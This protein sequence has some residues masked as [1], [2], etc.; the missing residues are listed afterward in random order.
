MD[1][2][3]YKE[4]IRYVC[5]FYNT[6]DKWFILRLEEYLN[7]SINSGFLD[8]KN[9]DEVCSYLKRYAENIF[10]INKLDDS[11]KERYLQ[12]KDHYLFKCSNKFLAQVSVSGTRLKKIASEVLI[13]KNIHNIV[14]IADSYDKSLNFNDLVQAGCLGILNSIQKYEVKNYFEYIIRGIQYEINKYVK[15]QMDDQKEINMQ[16]ENDEKYDVIENVE[17]KIFIEEFFQS[18]KG[19]LTKKEILVLFY[20]FGFYDGKKYSNEE[21]GKILAFYNNNKALSRVHVSKIKNSALFKITKPNPTFYLLLTY[22]GNIGLDINLEN[23]FYMLNDIEKSTYRIKLKE[24][25][26]RELTLS[27]Y[28]GCS[29]S[30]IIDAVSYLNAKNLKILLKLYGPCLMNPLDISVRNEIGYNDV[31]YCYYTLNN[32]INEKIKKRGNGYG[33][34]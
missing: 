20:S 34:K 15:S 14:K 17:R 4:V 1:N 29:L 32:I 7:D 33:L 24:K 22:N 27:E 5:R 25:L 21:I 3:M 12:L 19:L 6:N 31:C 11:F 26:G 8:N 28:L 23:D 2:L 30:Q 13:F 18:V 9:Y 10:Y 16:Y